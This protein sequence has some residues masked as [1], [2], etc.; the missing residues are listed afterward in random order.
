MSF[1]G[2]N[3]QEY[4]GDLLFFV[5]VLFRFIF[6]FFQQVAES[7]FDEVI[8]WAFEINS[9]LFGFFLEVVF[10]AGCHILASHAHY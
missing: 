8:E 9:E 2:L 10:D 7:F 4:E 1:Y 6:V 3:W 5:L